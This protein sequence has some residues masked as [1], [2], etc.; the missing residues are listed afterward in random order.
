MSGPIKPQDRLAWHRQISRDHELS[1]PAIHIALAISNHFNNGSGECFVGMGRL[2]D[3]VGVHRATAVK[4]VQTLAKRGHLQVKQGG[5]RGWANTY[6][7]VVREPYPAA[8]NC[9]PS[10]TVSNP[11]LSSFDPVNCRP[12]ATP[13]LKENSKKE[14]SGLSMKEASKQATA[15]DTPNT[16]CR[17]GA[18]GRAILKVGSPQWEVWLRYHLA[19]GDRGRASLMQYTGESSRW[20]EWEEP[21]EWPPN[22]VGSR[23]AAR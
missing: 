20:G 21:A 10:A 6:S 22:P 13:T 14:E 16:P 11:K 23:S 5:G 12:Q 19:T 7:M 4:A 8:K 3:E 17:I 9:R 1:R 2:A 15:T 18:N